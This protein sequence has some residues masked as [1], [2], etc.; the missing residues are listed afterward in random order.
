M[1]GSHGTCHHR[2]STIDD[3][4]DVPVE[5]VNLFVAFLAIGG[6]FV[7]VVGIALAV[8]DRGRL[9]VVAPAA[10]PVA[11]LAA[12]VATAGSLYYSEIAGFAPCRLCWIQ[13]IF[14]Y[15]LVPIVGGLVIWP[16]HARVLRVLP[17]LLAVAGLGVSVYHRVEQQFPDELGG[18]CSLDNPC[19]G[20]WVDTFGLITIP[21]M[22]AVAFALVVFFV[23]VSFGAEVKRSVA[24]D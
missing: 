7:L 19:S 2:R 9:R 1:C 17:V 16:G 3:A 22:A 15:P 18:S 5:T 14:M 21:T 12:T 11:L 20:R 6:L 13:R 23:L 4:G 10:L 24:H 8:M